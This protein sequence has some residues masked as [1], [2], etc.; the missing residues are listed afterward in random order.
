MSLDRLLGS[1]LI[2]MQHSQVPTP[3]TGRQQYERVLD[4]AFVMLRWTYAHPDFPDAIAI[5]D[6]HSYN[7]F[8]VRG[9]IRVFDFAIDEFGWS[10]TRLDETF[11]QRASARFT[12]EDTIDGNGEY[13]ENSGAT[14]HHDYSLTYQRET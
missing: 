11:S 5:V 6:E 14:W 9:V 10:M 8:D 2:T 3:I 1:W 7:Y 4:G 13:S 12:G